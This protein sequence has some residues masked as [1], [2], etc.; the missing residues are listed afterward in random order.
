MV[1]NKFNI[2]DKVRSINSGK[3]LTIKEYVS[4]EG[5]YICEETNYPFDEYQLKPIKE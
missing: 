4:S 1:M 5:W 3:I 2:G